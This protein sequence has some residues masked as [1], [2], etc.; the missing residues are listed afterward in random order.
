MKLSSNVT[1]PPCHCGII[2]FSLTKRAARGGDE[3]REH[4]MFRI[5]VDLR[6]ERQKHIFLCDD[7]AELTA[8]LMTVIGF[9]LFTAQRLVG[10]AP[11]QVN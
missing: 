2:S 4:Y 9:D 1:I 10:A 7:L 6:G 5:T 8:T 11:M 3:Q